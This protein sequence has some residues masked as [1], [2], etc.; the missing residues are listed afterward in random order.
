MKKSSSRNSSPR[1][2][3]LPNKVRIIGGR[4]RGVRV[5][6]PSLAAIRPSPDRVRETLFNWLQAS[7]PGA[8]CLDLF[9][10]SGV[11][12]LEA[13]SRGAARAVFIDRN[14]SVARHIRMTLERLQAEAGSVE[15]ADASDYLQARP[16]AAFD[17]V[18]LDPP[19]GQGLLPRICELLV[20]RGWLAEG[21]H[22]YIE[23]EEAA[24]SPNLP[25]GY[26]LLRSK[27]A[28]Q[29]RYHLARWSPKDAGPG[30]PP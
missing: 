3:D 11:L 7:L 19:F 25:P 30:A 4:W 1:R 27:R 16:A 23:S 13:L 24:G 21:A 28:G 18:F 14:P 5:E 15:C 6:F 2:A 20:R 29:V 10:G 8:H 22:V 17:V 9:A 12:G 26:D